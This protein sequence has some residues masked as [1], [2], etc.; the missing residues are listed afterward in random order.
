ME[1][2]ETSLQQLESDS[3]LKYLAEPT[4]DLQPV[5][6][7]VI[8]KSPS[9]H[10]VPTAI[11][12]T[13]DLYSDNSVKKR[14][15]ALVMATDNMLQSIEMIESHNRDRYTYFWIFL[16]NFRLQ[17]VTKSKWESKVRLQDIERITKLQLT[18][19]ESQITRL[20]DQDTA[21]RNQLSLMN[22]EVAM[23]EKMIRASFRCISLIVIFLLIFSAR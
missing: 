3:N 9:T 18:E 21:L 13:L 17:F 4:I 6:Y 19:N 5:L 14:A 20:K 1:E 8:A 16:C 7:S 23:V 11:P 22:E 12:T 10:T 15:S 2:I